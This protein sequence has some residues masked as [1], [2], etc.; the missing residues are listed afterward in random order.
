[1]TTSKTYTSI[2]SDNNLFDLNMIVNQMIKH[3]CGD[4]SD[5]LKKVRTYFVH[6]YPSMTKEELGAMVAIFINKEMAYP[7]FLEVMDV[8]GQ[9]IS[10]HIGGAQHIPNAAPD[11]LFQ[12]LAPEGSVADEDTHAPIRI[13]DRLKEDILTLDL[14]KRSINVLRHGGNINTLFDLVTKTPGAL[15]KIHGAGVNTVAGII[16][17][18]EKMDIHFGMADTIDNI[19]LLE[20]P[21]HTAAKVK[22]LK[23]SDLSNCAAQDLLSTGH[24]NS[25][26]VRHIRAA[27][28]VFGLPLVD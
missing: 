6:M 11:G 10:I 26:D 28:A 1:M 7:H 13:S 15:R 16:K 18:M 27:L 14:D 9:H 5:Y 17:A 3:I 23:I 12:A 24:L 25:T 8:L 21:S 20:L 22:D 2:S 19:K 4:K